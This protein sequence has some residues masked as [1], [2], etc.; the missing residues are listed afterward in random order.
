MDAHMDYAR[1]V[2]V[3]C[4]QDDSKPQE[5]GLMHQNVRGDPKTY[6]ALVVVDGKVLF[7]AEVRYAQ[8]G[9]KRVRSVVSG[10]V[11]KTWITQHARVL[12][13]D[14]EVQGIDAY[15]EIVLDGGHWFELANSPYLYEVEAK[16]Q[17]VER[18]FER[19][20]GKAVYMQG[21][22]VNGQK[23][24]AFRV[25]KPNSFE[26]CWWEFYFHG[27]FCYCYYHETFC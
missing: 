22:I 15:H 9:F 27:K 10:V 6:A 21:K 14:G 11:D 1:V 3:R 4:L 16:G 23:H 13:D 19:L 26:E 8:P 2:R 7:E 25:W 5:L 24:G 17:A 20:N 18:R 12:T